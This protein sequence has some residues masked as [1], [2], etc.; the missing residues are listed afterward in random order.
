MIKTMLAT[1][2]LGYAS[3][4]Q[5]VHYDVRLGTSN[6][7]MAGSKITIDFYGDYD[8]AGKLPV[9]TKSGYK[10]FPGYFDDLEGGPR[11]TDDPGFQSFSNTFLYGEEVHFRALGSLS[12]WNPATSSWGEAS[13]GSSVTLYGGIPVDAWLNYMLNPG[14]ATYAAQYNYY[15]G[16]TV[17]TA[18]GIGGPETALIDGASQNGTFHSHLDWKLSDSAPA[19]AYMLTLQV[20][21][22]AL[23]NGEQKYVDSDPFHV[24][25]KSAG[26]SQAQFDQAFEQRIAAAVP[27]ADAWA[28]LLLGLGVIGT[29]GSRRRLR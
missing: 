22:P 17:Y 3:L 28:M 19:G 13:A 26:I 10:I 8:L 11:L 12:Y 7:A 18:D 5:A 16:G 14:N 20:W 6:G 23:V 15:A 27:E 25:F 1:V 9:D 24:V 29:Y 21:S 4:A 2:L